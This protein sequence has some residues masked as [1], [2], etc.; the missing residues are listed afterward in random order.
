MNQRKEVV[1]ALSGPAMFSL[2]RYIV[3]S[4]EAD[5]Q[6]KRALIWLLGYTHALTRPVALSL[7]GEAGKLLA[8]GVHDMN[9][10]GLRTQLLEFLRALGAEMHFSSH[11]GHYVGDEFHSCGGAHTIWIAPEHFDHT[12]ERISADMAGVNAVDLM[13]Y[14]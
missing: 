12:A 6:S 5:D 11:I 2:C 1:E 4:R 9:S 8:A 7:D 3:H 14:A 10:S 13:V